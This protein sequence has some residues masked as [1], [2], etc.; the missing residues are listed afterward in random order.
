MI[1]DLHIHEKTYSLD[2]FISIY[3]IV[4]DAKE[5]GLDAVCITDHD[6]VRFKEQ[7]SK[8]SRELK[9]KI[10]SG[11]E[12]FS[13]DG[14]IVAFGI[15]EIPSKRISAQ[16]FAKYV[17]ERGGV[18]IAAHPF[19]TNNRGLEDKIKKVKLLTGVEAFNGNTDEYN[20][21]KCSEACID[22]NL[23]RIGAS[24]AH[25]VGE[26]GKF[27]TKFPNKIETLEELVQALKNKSGSPVKY[28]NGIYISI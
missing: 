3:D 17:N 10:F 11:V 7:V 16:D 2:S 18:C 20:N 25:R 23:Q 22:N 8:Y 26:V 12:Y 27:A 13:L 9:F 6:D 21:F 28:E 24:D 5:K 19:R 1:I 14:D 15:E 4:H